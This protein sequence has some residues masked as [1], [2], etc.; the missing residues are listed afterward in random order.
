MV[1]SSVSITV[2]LL[3][4]PRFRSVTQGIASQS[5]LLGGSIGIAAANAETNLQARS[6]LGGI[7]SPSQISSLQFST[8]VLEALD[9]AQKEAVRVTYAGVWSETMKIC[10]YVAAGA[11]LVSLCTVK[12]TS[13]KLKRTKSPTTND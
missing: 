11:F 5:R 1:F 12:A 2:S 6:M 8:N 13:I 7:L 3:V 4:E 10:V 9:A